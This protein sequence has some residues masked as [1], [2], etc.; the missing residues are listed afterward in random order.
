MLLRR[1]LLKDHE[2]VESLLTG[3]EVHVRIA[4]KATD[5]PVIEAAVSKGTSLIEGRPASCDAISAYVQRRALDY[6]LPAGITHYAWRR[7]AGTRV[8]QDGAE[9]I[10]LYMI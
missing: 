7:S 3:T 4:D 10:E 8:G 5:L 2:S 9:V 6:G 1:K